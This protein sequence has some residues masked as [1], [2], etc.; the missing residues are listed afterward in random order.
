LCVV[1]V[2]DAFRYQQLPLHSDIDCSL[3]VQRAYVENFSIIN[4]I[5]QYCTHLYYYGGKWRVRDSIM[6]GNFV[7]DNSLWS[8][9]YI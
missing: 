4:L 9:G 3:I 7:V 6:N 2:L 5:R 1:V 8:R